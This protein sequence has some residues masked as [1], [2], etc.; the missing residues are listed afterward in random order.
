MIPPP[1]L[2]FKN[3]RNR[4]EQAGLHRKEF[5]DEWASLFKGNR[6][7]SITPDDKGQW[8]T[9]RLNLCPETI[10]RIKSNKL[11]LE[12]GEFAY[13]LRAALDG[14]IWDTVT[15]MQGTEPAPDAKG[16]SRLE[17]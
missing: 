11:S 4:L 9:I 1:E 16:L 7:I 3:S 2:R 15:Y 6:D 13:Q 17:F 5:E 12:L 10:A 14:L 8:W